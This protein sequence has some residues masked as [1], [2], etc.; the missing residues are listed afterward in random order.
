VVYP[1]RGPG[2]ATLGIYA[3]LHLRGH[4][5]GTINEF[6]FSRAAPLSA[7]AQNTNASRHRAQLGKPWIGANL[8]TTIGL[9]DIAQTKP[10]ILDYAHFRQSA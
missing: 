6:Q 7:P 3:V 2:T 1:I 5:T 9:L 8:G 10:G 4:D